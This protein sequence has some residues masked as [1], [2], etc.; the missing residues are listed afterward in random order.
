MNKKTGLIILACLILS[1]SISMS[2]N[3]SAQPGGTPLPSNT[4]YMA[5]SNPTGYK[6]AAANCTS[7]PLN[8]VVSGVAHKLDGSFTVGNFS[9]SFGTGSG[10]QYAYDCASGG[11]LVTCQV[12]NCSGQTFLTMINTLP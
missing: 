3:L 10:S 11:T 4:L 1:M 8:V 6:K 5:T 2:L 9:I 12:I 7:S